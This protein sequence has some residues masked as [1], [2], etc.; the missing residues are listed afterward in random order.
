MR[1][2]I[3]IVSM[4]ILVLLAAPMAA[5]KQ[6]AA[7]ST[8]SKISTQAEKGNDD[9]LYLRRYTSNNLTTAA[10]TNATAA[11]I[12]IN[13][14]SSVTQR[15]VNET[16]VPGGYNW[17]ISKGNY[18]FYCYMEKSGGNVYAS[19][20]FK[21]GYIKEDGAEETLIT[22]TGTFNLTGNIREYSIYGNRG[23]A[24]IPSGSKL[25]IDVTISA[26]GTSGKAAYFYYDGVDQKTRII[27]PPIS[28]ISAEEVSE[29]PFGAVFLPPAL[30]SAYFILKRRIVRFRA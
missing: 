19:V 29:F 15:W 14:R 30:L 7:K 8:P 3:L 11:N 12:T 16:A 2:S 4:L 17:S 6:A 26:S 20:T 28:Q 23:Q 18:T 13:V 21:F 5:M 25:F 24:S 1:R 22:A 10:P 9:I 27:T